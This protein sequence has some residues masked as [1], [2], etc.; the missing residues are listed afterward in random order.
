MGPWRIEGDPVEGPARAALST[1]RRRSVKGQ[2]EHRDTRA[3]D[4]S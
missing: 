2:D 4:Q 3:A 1:V